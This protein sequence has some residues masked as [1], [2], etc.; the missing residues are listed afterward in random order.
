[1]C[2][3]LTA[4]SLGTHPDAFKAA[5]VDKLLN[6]PESDIPDTDRVVL[7]ASSLVRQHVTGRSSGMRVA[8][9]PRRMKRP[10]IIWDRQLPADM[11]VGNPDLAVTLSERLN[12]THVTPRIA[13]LSYGLV[14]EELRVVG[15]RMPSTWKDNWD[16]NTGARQRRVADLI[17]QARIHRP[18]TRWDIRGKVCLGSKYLK[19]V[20]VEKKEY[21]VSVSLFPSSISYSY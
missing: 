8:A 2:D 20:T 5:D 11:F 21:F 19:K 14:G 3:D 16:K 17:L 4:N 9:T 15:A 10:H 12:P 13:G 1:M 7:K 18:R 6:D